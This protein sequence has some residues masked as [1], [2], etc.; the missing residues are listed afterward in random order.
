MVID[1]RAA[2]D[3]ALV[4]AR[5]AGRLLRA[6]L[7]RPGGPRGHVDKAEADTEAD[8][9][10]DKEEDEVREGEEGTWEAGV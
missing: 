9:E 3:V 2:L 10:A 5:E 8:T 4:A 1:L 7:H 6:D